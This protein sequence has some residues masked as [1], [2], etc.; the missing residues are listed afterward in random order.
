MYTVKPRVCGGLWA[1]RQ[2]HG[3]LPDENVL[4]TSIPYSPAG[5]IHTTHLDMTCC[6]RSA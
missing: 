1:P 3:F 5:V 2:K 6:F 4:F